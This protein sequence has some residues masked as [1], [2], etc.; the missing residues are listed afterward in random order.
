[1]D[2]LNRLL[3]KNGKNISAYGKILK[4]ERGG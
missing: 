4:E 1:M 3:E 2:K